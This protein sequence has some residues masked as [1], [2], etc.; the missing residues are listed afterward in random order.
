MSQIKR[1]I[2]KLKRRL[3]SLVGG[4]IL[5]SHNLFHTS[6]LFYLIKS[7]TI[8]HKLIN[9]AIFDLTSSSFPLF[10]FN[11]FQLL[12]CDNLFTFPSYCTCCSLMSFIFFC[13]ISLISVFSNFLKSASIFRNQA[14]SGLILFSPL[15]IPLI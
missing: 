3:S 13:L 9:T 2:R 15:F 6:L 10:N 7:L 11:F 12:L 14:G 5:L 4:K 1:A 8:I